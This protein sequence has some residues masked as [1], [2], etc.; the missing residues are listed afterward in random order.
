MSDNIFNWEAKGLDP[1]VPESPNPDEDE[2]ALHIS[3][4]RS[5]PDKG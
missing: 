1:A 3:M 2:L 4:E 5:L